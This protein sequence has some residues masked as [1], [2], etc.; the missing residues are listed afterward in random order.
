MRL[1]LLLFAAELIHL[2]PV[3][4]FS[5]Q[6]CTVCHRLKHK[7]QPESFGNQAV[8]MAPEWLRMQSTNQMEVPGLVYYGIPQYG[9]GGCNLSAKWYELIC[10]GEISATTVLRDESNEQASGITVKYGVRLDD[11]IGLSEYVIMEDTDD[12]I[13]SSKIRERIASINST[14]AEMQREQQLEN[15]G[16][17]QNKPVIQCIHD[18]DYCA[19]LQLIRTMRPPRSKSMDD[20]SSPKVSCT[21]PPYETSNS[22]LVGPLRLYGHGDFHGEGKPRLCVERLAVPYAD[23]APEGS[24]DESYWDVYHNISP[25]DPRGHFL[26]LPTFQVET[27][28]RDQSLIAKDCHDV[29]YLASTIYPLGSLMLSF[30]SVGAGASQ[31]H[32]HLHAWV[33]P[34]PP[35]L[36]STNKKNGIHGYAVT[37]AKALSGQQLKLPHGTTVSLLDYPCACIKL[38]ISIPKTS[39]KL[40][41]FGVKEVGDSIATI[42][43]LAQLM[44]APHNVAWTNEPSES[45]NRQNIVGFI[46]IRSKS[47]SQIPIKSSTANRNN[48]QVDDVMRCGASEMLGLFHTS[49][50]WQLDALVSS[51]GAM[52]R[53]L[54]DVSWEPREILWKKIC[55]ELKR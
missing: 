33:C 43:K 10:A 50:K 24:T 9:L 11:E 34:S 1:L 5:Y 25:V 14:L 31:N 40:P 38:S 26:L 28:W 19:Q 45:E 55:E 18:G 2:L 47:L 36:D 30:N 27:N 51:R 35:L 42:V 20:T 44:E 13:G 23:N 16:S 37:E 54:R 21:P 49:S 17:K 7:Y 4:S 52:A 48:N 41:S 39:D 6:S 15:K 8:M 29:T 32:I 53:I 3:Q 46:F 22:F 12:D